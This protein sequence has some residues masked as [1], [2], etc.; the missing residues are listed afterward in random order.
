M[1]ISQIHFEK[2]QPDSFSAAGIYLDPSASLEDRELV[3]M[4][5]VLKKTKQNRKLLQAAASRLQ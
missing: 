2:L 3:V 5:K 4:I 1:E